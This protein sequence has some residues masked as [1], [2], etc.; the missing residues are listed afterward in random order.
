MVSNYNTRIT[1]TVPKAVND[2][3]DQV[4]KAYEKAGNPGMT[5]TVLVNMALNLLFKKVAEQA[6]QND[7]NNKTN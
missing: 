7:K 2:Y 3:M 6:E 4:C 5:K 1:I